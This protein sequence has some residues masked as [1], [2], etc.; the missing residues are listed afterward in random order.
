M[1]HKRNPIRCEKI[2]GL[3]RVL[4]ANVQAGLENIVIEHERDLTNSSCERVLLP[5][6][7]LL[8]DEML[9]TS[10]YV[11]DNIL[12]FPKQMKRNL[13]LTHGL[14]MAEA[15]M[16]EL[17]R[18]GMNRQEAHALLRKCSST[19]VR[20]N[21]PLTVVLRREGR[22]TRYIPEREIKKLIDP[23]KYLGSAAATVERVVKE[24]GPLARR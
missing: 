9:K 20:N 22:V 11:L 24:L 2:C 14:N 12:V 7:F 3:A 10:I 1:P 4:R 21:I 13:E 15:V 8:A 23:R 17:T 19:S 6:C 18:R 5:E 16:I